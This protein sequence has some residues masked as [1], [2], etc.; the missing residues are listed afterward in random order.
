[1]KGVA[2]RPADRT[3]AIVERESPAIAA[4]AQVLL[5]VLEVGICGT[6]REIAAFQFGTPPRAAEHL[7]IGHEA[8]AEV[9][10]VGSGVT[11]VRPG[12]VVVPMV[13]RP[14]PDAACRPCRDDR[15]DFC[16]TGSFLEHGIRGAH[17]FLTERLVEDERYLV[18][19]PPALREVAV[20]VEPLTIA[21]KAILQLQTVQSR[22]PWTCG[23]ARELGPGH[24]HRALVLGAGPVGLLG[25]MALAVRGF[26][27][28]VL[29]LEAED[30]P[31]AHLARAIGARYLRA[32]DHPLAGLAGE[33]GPIDVLYEA[34]GASR[35]ALAALAALAPNAIAILTGV[36]H[37]QPAAFDPDPF[38]RGLVLG[39]QVLLGTVNA[40]PDAFAAAVADLGEFDRRW[41][42]PLRALVTGRFPIDAYRELLLGPPRGIKNLVSFGGPAA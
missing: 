34:A 21:E 36:P 19:V 17:G 12:D 37:G 22:L 1:M 8:S 10:A 7:V 33:L 26:D 3:L 4:P 32:A 39:N 41:P 11:R 35:P 6:D 20:L 30:D 29:S 24:C 31:K 25:A 15:P 38:V 28:C 9:I 5:R 14:C 13:R 18:P 2:V 27:T 23:H 40:G 16:R 42:G